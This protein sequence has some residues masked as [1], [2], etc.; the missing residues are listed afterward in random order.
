MKKTMIAGILAATLTGAVHAQSSNVQIYGLID[1]GV[2]GASNSGTANGQVN[3]VVSGIHSASHLGFR[4]TEDLGGGLKAGFKIESQIQADDG[5]NGKSNSTGSANNTFARGV[6]VNLADASW[7][8]VEIGRQDN[9]A[10][11]TY[12]SLD[13]RRHSNFGGNPVMLSDGSS[14]GGTATSKTGLNRYTGGSHVSQ[15]IRY[16]TPTF[17]GFNATYARMF[18]NVAGDDSKSAADQYVVRYDNKGMVFGA[19]GYYNTNASTGLSQGRNN[20]AG[21]GVRATKDLT[22]MA[23][24][25]NMENPNGA[26]AA[27]TKFEL[28]SAGARYQINPKLEASYGFYQLKDKVTSSNGSDL[29]SAGLMYSLSPRT[30]L[31]AMYSMVKNK[32]TSGFAAWGGGG[33]NLNTLSHSYGLAAAGSSQSAYAV[34]IRHSF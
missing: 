34:G 31:L 17:A 27:N 20:F 1:T 23:N 11:S 14:F 22:L 15:A 16:D 3:A 30:T 18:G 32:G 4:G 19:L 13:A 6:S 28:T 8:R 12:S 2:I 29:N 21:V 33:S 24:R 5:S 7:G 26:G 10:W 25:W 9:A